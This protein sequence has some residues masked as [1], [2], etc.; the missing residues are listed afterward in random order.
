[1]NGGRCQRID[2]KKLRHF[3]GSYIS[4]LLPLIFACSPPGQPDGE[5]SPNVVATLEATQAVFNGQQIP[6][7]PLNDAAIQSITNNGGWTCSGTLL[8]NNFVLTATHCR[9]NGS[10][11]ITV[12]YGQTCVS[13]ANCNGR[14][15]CIINANGSFCGATV[16]QTYNNPFGGSNNQV[17]LWRLSNPI[18]AASSPSGKYN[19]AQQVWYGAKASVLNQPVTALG[20]NICNTTT[21]FGTLLQGQFSVAQV[22]TTWSVLLNSVNGSGLV[23]GDSGGPNYLNSSLTNNTNVLLG[24]TVQT[25]GSCVANNV[26]S[27][28]VITEVQAWFDDSLFSPPALLQSGVTGYAMAMNATG[29]ISAFTSGPTAYVR[30]CT[31]EP[32]DARG[33]W[34][35]QQAVVTGSV[36]SA[37]ALATDTVGAQLLVSVPWPDGS[38]NMYTIGA[39][40][41]TAPLT[42]LGGSCASAPAAASRPGTNPPTID[43]GCIGSD[44]TVWMTYRLNGNWRSSGVYSIGKP[45][46][47][48]ITTAAPAVVSTDASTTYVFV[49]ATDGSVRFI[50]GVSGLG[51]GAWSTLAGGGI[52]R[53]AAASYGP[54]RV[55]VVAVTNSGAM[56]HKFLDAAGWAPNWIQITL[57]TWSP[58]MTPFAAAFSG[59]LA[60][61]NIGSVDA[62]SNAHVQRYSD[63]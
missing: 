6:A 53:V 4:L 36:I 9:S 46:V 41:N 5:E 40:G 12:T 30:T 32:C 13:D 19:I 8:T 62:W 17:D 50:K 52:T 11:P 21:P 16:V 22:N 56:Y 39:A 49:A 55:D 26:G 25:A 7:G 34:T 24:P 44:G 2:M 10:S 31:T 29:A 38:G 60:K 3:Q 58:T 27:P 35:P 28:H 37:P 20:R 54:N 15:R 23:S 14:A 48:L 33:T 61:I 18:A 51:W 57:G 43:V 1:M 42:L 47:S 63:F 59:Q 45:A